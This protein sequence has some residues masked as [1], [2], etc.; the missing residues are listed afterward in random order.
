MSMLKLGPVFPAAKAIE[1]EP[2]SLMICAS[3]PQKRSLPHWHTSGR[4]KYGHAQLLHKYPAHFVNGP[5]AMHQVGVLLGA[6]AP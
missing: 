3:L 4:I 1:L 2:L 5:L 6:R